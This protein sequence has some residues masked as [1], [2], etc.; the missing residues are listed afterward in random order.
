MFVTVKPDPNPPQSMVASPKWIIINMTAI[1]LTH[2]M[3]KILLKN[4]IFTFYFKNNNKNKQTIFLN[5]HSAGD[6][7]TVGYAI[8]IITVTIYIYIFEG[9]NFCLRQRRKKSVTRDGKL[10]F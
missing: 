5:S 6:V 2:Y 3:T 9:K 4:Y 1:S 10:P 8:Q 7:V